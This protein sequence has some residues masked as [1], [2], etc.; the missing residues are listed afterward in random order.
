MTHRT[1]PTFRVQAEP[2]HIIVNL[3][4]LECRVWNAITETDEQLFLFVHTVAS[5][6]EIKALLERSKPDH[7]TA[8]NEDAQKG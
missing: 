6:S 7:I 8:R 1:E 2:S 4:G 5:P 3:D